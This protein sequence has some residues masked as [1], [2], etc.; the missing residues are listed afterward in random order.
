MLTG[1]IL[2]KEIVLEKTDFRE[3]NSTLI[4]SK[5]ETRYD[6]GIDSQSNPDF[7]LLYQT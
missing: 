6:K 1:T 5:D 7:N 4:I 3:K 2:A